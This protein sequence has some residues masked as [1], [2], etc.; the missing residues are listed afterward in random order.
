VNITSKDVDLDART[1]KCSSNNP[2]KKVELLIHGERDDIALLE[3]SRWLQETLTD[4]RLVVF[5]RSGHLPFL[6]E[7]DAFADEVAEFVLGL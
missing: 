1:L 6:E 4:A 3:S 5:Q 7:A 2:I